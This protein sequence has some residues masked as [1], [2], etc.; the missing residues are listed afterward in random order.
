MKILI[1]VTAPELSVHQ[2][3]AVSYLAEFLN[4]KHTDIEQPVT[5]ALAALLGIDSHELLTE[6]NPLKML[7]FIYTNLHTLKARIR[8][9]LC[10]SNEYYLMDLLHQ[11]LNTV[12]N[13]KINNSF[14]GDI[15]SNITTKDEVA[16]IRH[17]NGIMVHLINSDS[18][19]K[20]VVEHNDRDLII[21]INKK[22]SLHEHT[23]QAL[24][25]VIAEH[26]TSPEVY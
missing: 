18:A 14:S 1:G 17:V 21:H 4:L 8:K 2:R 6:F 13:T 16:Y 11:K 19:V 12:S 10:T 15:V 23:L 20:T 9:A 24:A 5:D 26:F 25:N 7:P 22:D 3:H